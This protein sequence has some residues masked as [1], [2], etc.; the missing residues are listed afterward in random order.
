MF[1]RTLND[2]N[3][4][5]STF[6]ILIQPHDGATMAYV[7]V[8]IDPA[9]N[10]TRQRIL[11]SLQQTD[12]IIRIVVATSALGL[13]VDVRNVP[14]KK[15]TTINIWPRHFVPLDRHFVPVSSQ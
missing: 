9:N 11:E 7:G 5:Q 2:V 12:G 15:I 13:G 1:A 14:T 3:L 4:L 10:E 8:F 6:R